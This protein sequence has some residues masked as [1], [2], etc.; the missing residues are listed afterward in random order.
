MPDFA[1]VGDGVRISAVT[2]DSAAAEAGLIAG[3]VLLTFD[4]EP[5]VDLQ[6]YSNLLRQS[7]PGDVV[8][9]Q[10]RRDQQLVKV[11]AKLKPR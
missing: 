8:Q 9:I 4:G 5:V 10:L 1:Y 7:A 2:P 6:T 3:D 11:D